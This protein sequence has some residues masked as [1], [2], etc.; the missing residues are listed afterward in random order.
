MLP[1]DIVNIIDVYYASLCLFEKTQQLNAQIRWARINKYLTVV[2][3]H[4][5]NNHYI[6][7]VLKEL[8]VHDD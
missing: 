2:F 6:L 4:C 5:P 1:N 8:K 7:P 3:F